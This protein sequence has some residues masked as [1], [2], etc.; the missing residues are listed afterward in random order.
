[1]KI[2]KLEFKNAIDTVSPFARSKSTL[3]V[4]TH[5]KVESTGERITFTASHVDSQIEHWIDCKGETFACCIE[6][7]KLKRF[8]QFLAADVTLTVKGAKAT[9]E[10]GDMKTRLS[11]LPAADFPMLN[12]SEKIITEM[13]WAPIGAKI[14]FATQFCAVQHSTPQC[15]CV[16]VKSTGQAI[17]IMATDQKSASLETVP[18]IAP[19]FGVCI[20]VDTA[21]HMVGPFRSLVVREEQLELR[22]PNS[23]ALFKTAPH[24]P[25]NI[26]KLFRLN[27]PNAGEVSRKALLDAIQF[28]SSFSD[29]GKI[30][31]MVKLETGESNVVRLAGAGNEATAPFDYQGDTLA[32]AGYH[33]DWAQFMKALEGDK[34]KIMFNKD[35]MQRTQIRLVDDDR[36]ILTM[37]ALV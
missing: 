5:I 18:H 34:L 28:V 4:L 24:A 7:D 29:Q 10:S 22:G 26:S 15:V 19:E 1:M 36:M 32:F 16:N 23:I 9:L 13:D 21:R 33:D 12:K 25:L 3:A 11:V 6:A 20:P 27:L 14:H 37:P 2:P 17:E 8:V 31:G 35:D 30:R